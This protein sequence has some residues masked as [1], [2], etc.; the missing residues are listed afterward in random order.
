[1]K[2]LFIP[3]IFAVT[4]INSANAFDF[5]A[6]CKSIDATSFSINGRVCRYESNEFNASIHQEQDGY[7]FVQLQAY[8]GKTTPEVI[9]LMR[10]LAVIMDVEIIDDF[11]QSIKSAKPRERVG[12]K[13]KDKSVFFQAGSGKSTGYNDADGFAIFPTAEPSNTQSVRCWP[14]FSCYPDGN[15]KWFGPTYDGL[16]QKEKSPPAK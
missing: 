10:K 1:M 5:K 11:F 7:T 3:L 12:F 13:Y 14:V 15:T 6:A 9:E 16:T 2:K 4:A 8:K